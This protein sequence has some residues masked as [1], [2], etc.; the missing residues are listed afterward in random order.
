MELELRCPKDE[1]LLINY[2]APSGKKLHNRLWNGGTGV[3]EIRL[4]TGRGTA[5]T[6]V[7]RIEMRHVGCE[8]G[9]YGAESEAAYR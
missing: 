5:E 6:L 4:Y 8:Y 9:E 3:G 1:M 2:E 7:D